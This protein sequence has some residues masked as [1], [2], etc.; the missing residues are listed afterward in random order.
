MKWSLGRGG[1]RAG[2][3][4]SSTGAVGTSFGSS[5][6][7][8]ICTPRSPILLRLRPANAFTSLAIARNRSSIMYMP[9]LPVS[10]RIRSRKISQ[11]SRALSGAS[12]PAWLSRCKR[13][14]TLIMEPRFS[15]NP[16]PGQHHGRRRRRAVG[17]DAR[18]DEAGQVVQRAAP[19]APCSARRPRPGRPA[20]GCVLLFTPSM[21]CRQLR[22]RRLG[23][24]AQQLRA[25]R[26]SGCGRRSAG[27]RPPSPWRGTTSIER[28]TGAR[29]PT[30]GSGRVPRS[31]SAHWR[32]WQ[33]PRP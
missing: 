13:P 8:T 29:R 21:I 16:A 1:Q 19:S 14:L 28:S 7:G 31:S 18:G 11:S 17:Q 20:R 30:A 27:C 23:R 24:H 12:D 15:A 33:F 9:L 26:C 4:V 32:G 10:P 5:S 22:A 6:S 3:A 25:R 2:F